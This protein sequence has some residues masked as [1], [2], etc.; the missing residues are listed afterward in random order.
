[1][2]G[3]I[4]Y[5]VKLNSNK[6][7]E[8][9]LIFIIVVYFSVA[10]LDIKL[11]HIFAVICVLIIFNVIY[12]YQSKNNIDFFTEIEAKYN[13]LLDFSEMDV[14]LTMLSPQLGYIPNGFNYPPKHLYNDANLVNLYDDIKNEFYIYNP[15]A[16]VKSILAANSLLEI[17][18]DFEK[19]LTSEVNVPDYQNNNLD[20]YNLEYK[21]NNRRHGIKDGLAV[22]SI[23]EDQYKLALNHIQSFIVTIPSNPDVHK[24]FQDILQRANIL[25]KR[26]LDII[27]Q[28]YKKYKDPTEMSVTDYD[29]PKPMNKLDNPENTITNTFNFF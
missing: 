16:Y 20:N 7:T 6:K 28:N 5:F 19:V 15:E 24:K 1:M 23:A 17:R 8:Y 4:D 21:Q 25:L 14:P 29:L 27:H 13:S 18:L 2:E 26:N 10:V 9:I 11:G 22:F 12:N 3:F